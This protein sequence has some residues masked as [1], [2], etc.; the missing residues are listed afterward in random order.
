MTVE[1]LTPE[2]VALMKSLVNNAHPVDDTPLVRLLMADRVLMG[3]TNLAHL[4]RSGGRLLA[5]Y[6][7]AQMESD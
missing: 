3:S 2:A 4:T 1:E 7:A 5:A 6:R